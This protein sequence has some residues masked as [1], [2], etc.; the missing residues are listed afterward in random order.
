MCQH[1]SVVEQFE[2]T[3]SADS[4]ADELTDSIQTVVIYLLKDGSQ[5]KCN[6]QRI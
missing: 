5:N 2:L 6:R 3:T 4:G 1:G